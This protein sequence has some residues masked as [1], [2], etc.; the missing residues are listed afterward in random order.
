M[1]TFNRKKRIIFLI[2]SYLYISITTI[3]Y[4]KT[5]FGSLSSVPKEASGLDFFYSTQGSF[6][7]ALL[8]FFFIS[9]MPFIYSHNIISA[10]NS[11]FNNFM[12]TRLGSKKTYQLKAIIS[13]VVYSGGVFL[14]YRILQLVISVVI[15]NPIDFK[16]ET[17]NMM[18]RLPYIFSMN[19]ILNLLFYLILSTIGVIIFSN[20][21][22]SIGLFLKNSVLY[23]ATGLILSL[24]F[25]LVPAML[26]GIL[27]IKDFV[28]SLFFNSIYID[29][30]VTPGLH[31]LGAYAPKFN[32][33]YPFFGSILFFSLLTFILYKI[34]NRF[35]AE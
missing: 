11:N 30:L 13:N 21:I 29:T 27:N 5:E 24:I 18:Y 34:W 15:I 35:Y 7:S 19:S 23:Y 2:C 17:R 14:S 25:S 31:T 3:L 16:E 20:F 9:V 22:L 12:I 10:K 4:A 33:W 26:M 1:L 28:G 6:S 32:A 8:F